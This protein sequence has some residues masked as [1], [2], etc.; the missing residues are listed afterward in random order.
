M[1]L[2][3]LEQL[4]VEFDKE[5]LFVFTNTLPPGLPALLVNNTVLINKDLPLDRTIALLAEEIGHHKTLPAGM[6][7]TDYSKTINMKLE[8]AGRKW[9][10][11][12]LLPPEKLIK[13]KS[14]SDPVLSYQLADEFGLPVDFVEEA[15]NQ[16][17][18]DEVI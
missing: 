6:D 16:Y 13:Y 4:M 9:S 7:I 17:K 18:L 5:L 10:Y 2:S 12:K 14:S 11:Y 3:P 15:I 1:E 8:R